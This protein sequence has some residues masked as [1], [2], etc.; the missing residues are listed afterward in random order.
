MFTKKVIECD[1]NSLQYMLLANSFEE[2]IK[3]VFFVDTFSQLFPG[4]ARSISSNLFANF[5]VS[6]FLQ[7]E[8]L[9]KEGQGQDHGG[10]EGGLTTYLVLTILMEL[11]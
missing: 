8:L 9:Q 4:A 7:G 10:A 6:T 5:F 11:K 2:K 1:K 3:K